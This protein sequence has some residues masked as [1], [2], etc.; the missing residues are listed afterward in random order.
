MALYVPCNCTN[1]PPRF[2][3]GVLQKLQKR[4]KRIK[5]LALME[6]IMPHGTANRIHTANK[7]NN[8]LLRFFPFI[9]S[10]FHGEYTRARELDNK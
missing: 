1:N 5:E 2:M 3:K 8:F 9:A 6:R 4:K 10:A 7:Y